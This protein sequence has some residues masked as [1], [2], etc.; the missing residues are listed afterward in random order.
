MSALLHCK[1]VD[2]NKRALNYRV[3]NPTGLPR[4]SAENS[5]PVRRDFNEINN[6]ACQCCG[7]SG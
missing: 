7:E 1:S 2:C 4:A 5:L 6:F 3:P